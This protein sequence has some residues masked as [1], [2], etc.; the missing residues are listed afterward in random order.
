MQNLVLSHAAIRLTFKFLFQQLQ[1]IDNFSV[2][3][4]DL[5]CPLTYINLSSC[6][7]DRSLLDQKSTIT[8]YFNAIV[9]YDLCH[10]SMK[11]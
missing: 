9:V 2:N 10:Y 4:L 7:R 5:E 3:F 11:C 8:S 1:T 6:H